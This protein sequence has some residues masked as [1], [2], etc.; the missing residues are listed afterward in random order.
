MGVN[1]SFRP[2]RKLNGPNGSNAKRETSNV[3]FYLTFNVSRPKIWWMG[4]G[5]ILLL[6]ALPTFYLLRSSHRV[7]RL[8]AQ[9]RIQYPWLRPHYA[10]LTQDDQAKAVAQRLQTPQSTPATGPLRVNPSNSHYFVDDTGRAVY[11][12]GSHTW[13]NLQDTGV[14]DPPPVFDYAA[15]L[16]FLNDHHQNF[17]RLYVQ[18][19]TIYGPW[20]DAEIRFA[21]HPYARTGPGTA[22]DGKPKFDLT[23]F[24]QAFFDRMRER[25]QQAGKHG[26]YVSVML[27][28]GWSIDRK[29]LIAPRSAA[30]PPVDRI[31]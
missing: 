23:Q 30:A 8:I 27:F 12:T 25:L 14:G 19:Q 28:N 11:L 4:L 2:F 5:L 16:D 20:L 6:C 24:N 29:D 31:I 9:V 15:Y 3:N 1:W 17:F 13:S 7:E 22:L 26:I 18:E 21:P 10:P